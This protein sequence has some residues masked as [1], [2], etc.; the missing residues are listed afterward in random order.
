MDD[1]FG[2]YVLII[3]SGFVDISLSANQIVI[4]TET[5]AWMPV[6]KLVVGQKIVLP[7]PILTKYRVFFGGEL[8]NC[9]SIFC[10][11]VGDSSTVL[12]YTCEECGYKYDI[13]G[14]GLDHKCPRCFL[15]WEKVAM[16]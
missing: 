3:N 6:T 12:C 13:T 15:N 9:G 1:K 16:T 5:G 14:G 2:T 8:R 4:D 7:D 10:M 11:R